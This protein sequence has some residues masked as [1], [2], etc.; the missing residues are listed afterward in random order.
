MKAPPRACDGVLTEQVIVRSF[1]IVMARKE[2]LDTLNALSPSAP[3]KKG[4]MR[5]LA[6]LFTA[7]HGQ[8]RTGADEPLVEKMVLALHGMTADRWPD[9]VYALDAQAPA[10]GDTRFKQALPMKE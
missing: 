5:K 6:G 1:L 3:G 4:L 7:V 8:R 2:T 9:T 10:A